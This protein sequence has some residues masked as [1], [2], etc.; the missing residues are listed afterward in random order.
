M[1]LVQLWAFLVLMLNNVDLEDAVPAASS[2]VAI[3]WRIQL[4]CR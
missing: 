2:A 3:Q 4:M 1:A